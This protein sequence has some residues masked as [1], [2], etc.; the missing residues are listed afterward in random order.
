MLKFLLENEQEG[1]NMNIIKVLLVDDQ[2]LIIDGLKTILSTQENI[3]IVSEATNGEEAIKKA[4][5]YNPDIILMDIK[6]PGIDGVN[7][8]KI[9]LAKNNDIKIL[10]LTTFDDDEYIIDALSYGATGYILKDI[11]GQS[12]IK[13]VKDAYDDNILLPGKIAKKLIANFNKFRISKT[14]NTYTDL[15]NQLSNREFEVA[16][17]IT[18]GLDSKQIAKELYLTQGTVKNYMSNIYKIIG[19]NDRTKAA[20]FLKKYGL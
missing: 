16:K 13:A 18:K 7:A 14:E 5:I 11:D 4:E 20:I 8:T 6:M 10:I 19:T 17:L 9:I 2:P 12:L 1:V 3:K 15:A